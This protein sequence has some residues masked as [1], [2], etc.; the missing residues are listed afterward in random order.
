MARAV[1]HLRLRA[2]RTSLGGD[3]I[4]RERMDSAQARSAAR[5]R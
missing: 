5:R 1:V 3:L 2:D 4:E